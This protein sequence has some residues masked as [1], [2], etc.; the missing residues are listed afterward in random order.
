MTSIQNQTH[1]TYYKI[2]KSYLENR[3]FRSTAIG[4][5]SIFHQSKQCSWTYLI[6][7]IYIRSL[8]TTYTIT[9]TFHDDT[10]IMTIN[11]DPIIASKRLQTTLIYIRNGKSKLTKQ[12]PRK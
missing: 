5:N 3:K 8:T 11:E 2:L 7:N 10:I 1:T 4:E 6:L 12:N 9:E